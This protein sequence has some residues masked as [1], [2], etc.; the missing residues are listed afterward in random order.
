MFRVK[1]RSYP[2]GLNSTMP[3]E[4]SPPPSLTVSRFDE[5][6]LGRQ[7]FAHRLQRFIEIE[8]Q[9]VEGSLVIGLSA[10][11]G[12]GKTTFLNMWCDA[13]EGQNGGPLMI[14]LN[15]WESDYYGDPL[16]AVVSSLVEALKA[17]G[18]SSKRIVDAAKDIG[19]FATA[20]T[21]QIV[22]KFT[23]IDAVAAGDITESK[24]SKRGSGNKVPTDAFSAYEARKGVMAK[25]KKAIADHISSAEP[26]VIFLVDELDRCR[27]DF[28]ISYLE[29]IK[30]IFDLPGAVFVLAADRAHLE[31]SAK[32]AFGKDLDFEEYYRKF[33]LREVEL[34]QISLEGYEAV[35]KR[36]VD[37]YLSRDDLRF[38]FMGLDRSR[39]EMIAELI[40]ILRM[41]P[42]Q[43]QEAFRVLGHLMGT[44]EELKGKLRWALAAGSVAMAI[45]RVGDRKLYKLL[46]SAALEPSE[47]KE[48]A[49]RVGQARVGWWLKLFATGGGIKRAEGHGLAEVLVTLGLA[50]AG[51]AWPFGIDTG[52]WTEGWGTLD[53]SRFVEIYCK[54]E[55]ITSW[56]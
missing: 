47:A 1:W 5:D 28:A 26:K 46:G 33:I 3:E 49:R 11:F 41:T 7:E 48:F 29:T 30:H 38:C 14:Y 45:L 24:R 21:G 10:R 54:I 55:E 27:P 16:F 31:N 40:E 51:E 17:D 9:F 32:T 56:Q 43:I 8:N 4:P 22:E 42:R 37:Y 23:G 52:Q 18:K 35:S 2:T 13:V 53:R 36:Y 12:S 39:R 6:L 20:I 25:L 15:A 50:K 19:W 44:T 34:P